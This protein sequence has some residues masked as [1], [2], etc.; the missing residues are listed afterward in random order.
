M[1]EQQLGAVLIF[2][3]IGFFASARFRNWV[4]SFTT[5]WT[6]RILTTI[7]KTVLKGL[8]RAVKKFVIWFVNLPAVQIR[9]QILKDKLQIGGNVAVSLGLILLLI[10]VIVGLPF[11]AYNLITTGELPFIHTLPSLTELIPF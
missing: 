6:A 1:Y 11:I 10:L 8:F 4:I 9:L 7:L 5:Y 2:L 3:F